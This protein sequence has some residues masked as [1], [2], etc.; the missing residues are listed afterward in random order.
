MV[1]IADSLVARA[2]IRS[3]DATADGQGAT[4]N[5]PPKKEGARTLSAAV[6][7]PLDFFY[8]DPTQPRKHFDEQ[9]L[10]LLGESLKKKQ[11]V[12]GIARKNGMIVDM[13]RRWR[14]ASLVGLKTL[15]VILVEDDVTEAQIKEIQ[16]V[17]SLHRAD[18]KPYE[19][20]CGFKEWLKHHPVATARELAAAIDRR[21]DYVSRVLSLDRCIQ[22]VKDAAAEGKLGLSDWNAISKVPDGEQAVLL[23]AKLNGASRDELESRGRKARNGGKPAVRVARVRCQMPSGVMV[24]LAGQGDGLTLSDIIEEL[25]ALLKEAK[26]ADEQ[27]LDSKTFSAVLRDKAKAS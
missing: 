26:K 6:S 23:A 27:G 14:A 11:L 22:A 16:L 7:K 21:E 12:P 5:S 18:L 1:P 2:A 20:Y 4:E 9:E 13:E 8:P 3:A 19:V 24:T 15:D 25:T 17:T 10:R